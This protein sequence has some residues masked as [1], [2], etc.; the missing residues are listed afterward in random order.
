LNKEVRGLYAG[1]LLFV[2]RYDEA[3][4]QARAILREQP[5]NLVALGAVVDAAHMK[6]QYAEAIA[7][8]AVLYE[9]KGWPDIAAVLKK[10]YAESGYASALRQATEVELAKHGGE[11][12]VTMD[13][14]GNYTMAGDRA[15][16]LDWLEKAYAERD[17]GMAFIGCSPIYDPLRAE[18]RFQALLRKM[19]LALNSPPPTSK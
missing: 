19:N 2:R 13:A 6:Q 11:P 9:S 7:A 18:P 1:D 3:L 5:D 12:G 4:T 14:A 8:N 17:P 10:G 15:R 16:A